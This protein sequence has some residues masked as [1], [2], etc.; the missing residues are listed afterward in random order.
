MNSRRTISEYELCHRYKEHK[1]RDKSYMISLIKSRSTISSFRNSTNLRL[2]RVCHEN[3]TTVILQVTA[4]SFHVLFSR[5]FCY[6]FNFLMEII[7]FDLHVQFICILWY[8]FY[9]KHIFCWTIFYVYS[10][11]R[12]GFVL[13]K[14]QQ[15]V[16]WCIVLLSD[17]FSINRSRQT[18]SNNHCSVCLD[19][20]IEI[21][22]SNIW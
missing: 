13:I 9:K 11:A 22:I 1:P 19:D 8:C 5:F 6:R 3:T 17:T 2:Q 16:G 21:Y 4:M 10:R 12:G 7:P 20:V 15:N 18:D 14:Q